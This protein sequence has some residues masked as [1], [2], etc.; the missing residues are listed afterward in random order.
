M[1]PVHSHTCRRSGLA[2]VLAI[3]VICP[4]AK[5]QDEVD[6]AAPDP[7]PLDVRNRRLLQLRVRLLRQSVGLLGSVEQSREWLNRELTKRVGV[8]AS[9]Y[10]LTD[11]QKT[12]LVMAGRGDIKRVLD[13]FDA[14]QK[15][16]NLA[17]EAW[18]IDQCEQDA[19]RLEEDLQGGFF[20]R[21]SLFAKTMATTITRE[22]RAKVLE[23]RRRDELAR[24]EQRANLRRGGY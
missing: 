15:R 23:Q 20:G 5:A 6:P 24:R 3:A 16:F 14:L 19:A 7:G 21:E 11:A 1:S 18:K 12:K 10:Q 17:D 4:A 2:M 8:L 22:Q 9:E 13:R